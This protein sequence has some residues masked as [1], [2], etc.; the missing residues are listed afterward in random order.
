MAAPKRKKSPA[1]GAAPAP[2]TQ[3]VVSFSFA[4]LD[5]L[6]LGLILLFALVLIHRNGFAN[7]EELWPMPDAVEYAETAIDMD[8]GLGPV[9]HFAGDTYPTRYTIGYPL[10]LAVAYPLVGRRPELLCLATALMALVAIAGLY[11]LTQWAFDRPSAIIAALLLA[12]SPYFIGLATCV[13]SDVPSLA[14]TLLVALTFL[15]AEEN[16]S[17]IA[18]ALCGF[19]AGWAVTIR[20]TSIVILIGMAAALMLVKTRRIRIEQI[21]AFAVGFAV[22]PGV[23]ASVNSHYFGSPFGNGYAFWRPDLYRSHFELFDARYLFHPSVEKNIHGNLIAYLFALLGLDGIWGRL[24]IGMELRPL[25]HSR[26]SLYPFVAAIFAALGLMFAEEERR[27]IALRAIYF[28]AG[29]FGALLLI[30]LFYFGQD[31]R[32][33]M[34]GIF[35][36]LALAGYGV[37]AANRAFTSGWIRAG[38]VVLDL[39][40]AGA[41]ALE[42][43]SRLA[44]PGVDS[45]VV[46]EVHALKPRVANSVLVTDISLPWLDLLEGDDHI[47]LVGMDTLFAGEAINEYHLHFL[48]EKRASGQ[49]VSMP[50]VLLPNGQLDAVVAHQLADD[51]KRGR[52]VYLLVAMPMRTE[53]AGTLMGEFGEIDHS[54]VLETVQRYPEIALYRM[55]PR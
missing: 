22:L 31:V 43:F 10:L 45:K 5:A 14:T 27:P 18:A 12:T 11:L 19:I 41:V 8:R 20:I 40:L 25:L 46:A 33:L 28:G 17:P 36:V 23:Q 39:V 42:T 50:P 16:G 24:R 32:F 51:D 48:Y 15:Y 13:M 47:E 3:R 6:A 21:V 34:P 37:A 30:Y 1:R 55:K 38:V 29:V 9:L 35:I 44:T 54:F 2:E 53:W 49:P 26:Y 7:G 4:A 52:A